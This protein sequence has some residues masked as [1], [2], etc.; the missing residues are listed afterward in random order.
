M[1]VIV[2]ILLL[3]Q[4]FL[5]NAQDAGNKPMTLNE[6]L[7]AGLNI[8]MQAD[9]LLKNR[10]SEIKSA[11]YELL[12]GI[13]KLALMEEFTAELSDLERIA[14]LRYH[15][16]DNDVYETSSLL[17]IYADAKTNTAIASND[18]QIDQNLLNLYA[19]FQAIPADSAMDMYEIDKSLTFGASADSLNP[20]F[21]TIVANTK[22]K[23]DN[24]FWKIEYFRTYALDHAG[25]TEHTARA[26]FIAEDIDYIAYIQLLSEAL[27]IRLNYLETLNQY[28]QTAIEL[29]YIA[30]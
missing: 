30:Y 18:I 15:S 5:I 26:K 28:N 10:S 6:V 9:S 19:G 14:E 3:F 21:A 8:P 17:G 22:L 29:E 2:S 20:V 27:K 16:G 13:Q 24:L 25:I 11:W 23:L 4:A 1:R 12:Y 7:I